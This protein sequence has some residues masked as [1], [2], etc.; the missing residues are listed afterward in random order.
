MSTVYQKLGRMFLQQSLDNKSDNLAR[1]LNVIDNIQLVQLLQFN[2]QSHL[3]SNEISLMIQFVSFSGNIDILKHKWVI[4]LILIYHVVLLI[5]MTNYMIRGRTGTL[6]Y[7]Q[8]TILIYCSILV[9]PITSLTI[10]FIQNYEDFQQNQIILIPIVVNVF[11]I[12]IIQIIQQILGKSFNLDIDNCY[13]PLQQVGLNS[14]IRFY[15]LL[16]ICVAYIIDDKLTNLVL[17]TIYYLFQVYKQYRFISSDSFKIVQISCTQIIC[18]IIYFNISIV[19]SLV[20][21]M[22]TYGISTQCHQYLYHKLISNQSATDL[23]IAQVCSQ[24]KQQNNHNFFEQYFISY[25]HKCVKCKD[26]SDIGICILKKLKITQEKDKRVTLIYSDKI[27]KPFPIK[28]LI[29]LTKSSYDLRIDYRIRYACKIQDLVNYINQRQSFYEQ[30]DQSNNLN[31]SQTRQSVKLYQQTITQYIKIIKEQIQFWKNAQQGFHSYSQCLVQIKLLAK[32]MIKNKRY[33]RQIKEKQ[34]LNVI[35]L[36]VLQLHYAIVY[37]DQKK[38]FSYQK[39]IDEKLISD[40]YK[41]DK[42]INN[43][44]LY[45]GR[46]LLVQTSLVFNKGQLINFNQSNYNQFFNL[47]NDQ[48]NQI[49]S[50]EDLMPQF[51]RSTHNKFLDNYIRKGYSSFDKSGL[52]IFICN[53]EGYIIMARLQV[54]YDN[55]NMND[56]ILTGL[57]AKEYN[58]N[59]AIIISTEGQILG[60]DQESFEL[61][62][63][64]VKA[65][66]AIVQF[67]KKGY[68]IQAFIKNIQNSIE[69]LNKNLQYKQNSLINQKDQWVSQ[70]QYHKD[71]GINVNEQYENV[72]QEVIYKDN[73]NYE[74]ALENYIFYSLFFQTHYYKGGEMSYIK[75]VINDQYD[76]SN[77]LKFDQSCNSKNSQRNSN[78]TSDYPQVKNDLKISI[79]VSKLNQKYKFFSS[80]QNQNQNNDIINE[81]ISNIR[82]TTVIIPPRQ[83]DDLLIQQTQDINISKLNKEIL[84]RNAQQSMN[85]YRSSQDSIQLQIINHLIGQIGIA[86]PLKKISVIL[87]LTL[88]YIVITIFV[89]QQNIASSV[90]NQLAQ[91]EILRKPQNISYVYTSLSIQYLFKYANQ[92]GLIQLSPFMIEWNQIK[93]IYMQN[94][95]KSLIVPLNIEVSIIAD[96]FNISTVV[97]HIFINDQP[98]KK[99]VSIQQFYDQLVQQILLLKDVNQ[100][101]KNIKTLKSKGFLKENLINLLSLNDNL[102]KLINT[103]VTNLQQSEK[104]QFFLIIMI[105]LLILLFF[106]NIQLVWWREIDQ[107]II[108]LVFIIH[109]AKTSQIEQRI[110]SLQDIQDALINS[111]SWIKIPLQDLISQSNIVEGSQRKQQLISMMPQDNY[112]NKYNL[113]IC[114]LIF[115]VNILFNITGYLIYQQSNIKFESSLY[116]M[117]NYVQFLNDIDASFLYGC[118]IKIDRPLNFDLTYQSDEEE[119][120]KHLYQTSN[121]LLPQLN[122]LQQMIYSSQLQDNIMFQQLLFENLC[123]T[124][125][126]QLVMCSSSS[127]NQ[128]YWEK[129]QYNYLIYNGIIGYTNQFIKYITENYQYEFS[130]LSYNNIQSA[131]QTINQPIFQNFFLQYYLDMQETLRIFLKTF[132]E[133]NTRIG[134]D[135][136]QLLQ[137][138][139]IIFGIFFYQ[140]MES[141]ITIGL[142][143]RYHSSFTSDKPELQVISFKIIQRYILIQCFYYIYLINFQSNLEDMQ[144]ISE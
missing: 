142:N 68:F 7:I 23:N 132:Y 144:S 22:L 30:K 39:Q 60:M 121:Q 141:H 17:L 127:I 61:I 82:E 25:N 35:E 67:V 89:N 1:F 10:Q 96:S 78:Q 126:K 49:G 109:R 136:V 133:Q 74:N 128:E 123:Q 108:E 137:G 70:N 56:V 65:D 80:L 90:N 107:L 9:F 57:I 6:R 44:V 58:I 118:L 42:N 103:I 98:Q 115:L 138:Y 84:E 116:T 20:L 94:Y 8:H 106:Y 124:S 129:D 91:L 130:T 26:I 95:I 12:F 47:P 101:R 87:S 4:Y 135:I 19:G 24:L 97:E 102:L 32:I 72:N 21:I 99:E 119:I 36:K 92:Q 37:L 59:K 100:F 64:I 83:Q 14:F 77:Y 52:D 76:L 13:N 120:I 81:D 85:S 40:R 18:I 112:I 114:I 54:N 131:K 3:K 46:Y 51:K 34:N 28:A 75:I 86:K 50:I 79:K 134:Q 16:I 117:S 41:L 140:Q 63:N 105:E 55:S 69:L 104:N 62:K 122:I 139:Y 5:C 43:K 111:T 33:L 143:N 15:K 71:E 125:S 73:K 88:I 27:S 31:V 53:P 113:I 45:E 2:N 110:N 93:L 38:I 48:L 66:I 11:V 29:N